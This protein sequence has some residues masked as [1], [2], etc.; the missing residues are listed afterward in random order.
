MTPVNTSAYTRW[1]TKV[2][3][4]QALA[5][6]KGFDVEFVFVGA[7]E[8]LSALTEPRHEGRA[9]YWFS[10]DVLTTAW[11][12]RRV[13]EVVAKVGRRYSPQ[14]HVEVDTVQVFEAVARTDVYLVRW[15]EV[16][17]ELRRA[18]RWPWRAPADV[19]DLFDDPLVTC[20][21]ALDAMDDGLQAL[22][23]AASGTGALP[24]M[25]EPLAA[26]AAAAGAV[27]D[28]LREHC[29]TPG[30]YYVDAAGT[31]HSEIQAVL[32]LVH[33][34]EQLARS[35]AR[36]AADDKRLVLTGRAGVGKTHLLCDAASRRIA[37]G[38]PTLV[39]LGQDFDRRPLL[40][41]IGELT[42]LGG[43]PDDVIGVLDAAAQA[44]G[45][46]GLLMIDALNESADADR[47]AAELRALQ[48]VAA[49]FL[50]VAVVVSCRTEFVEAVLGDDD[51]VRVDH[52]GFGEAV[53]VAVA[54]FTREYGLEPP[55]FPV[56][57]PGV[58]QSAL[59]QADL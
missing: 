39:L 3:E 11:Q 56:L 34:A 46:L 4:W 17:A 49:R 36:R 25:T 58:R 30:G 12:R 16:L 24:R 14:L 29:R 8:L 47:W 45:E 6:G 9:R 38:R 59:P 19:A 28:L 40:S 37:A 23:I 7:H 41:Q 52:H 48:V 33:R 18:R 55:S 5:R 50:N 1:T 42:Q 10:T 26:A 35:S 51:S 54:R 31:L 15:R 2:A 20:A 13:E 21:A 32:G 27:D 53:D 43:T 22:I 57:N 44:A